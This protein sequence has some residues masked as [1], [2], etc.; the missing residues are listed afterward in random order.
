VVNSCTCGGVASSDAVWMARAGPTNSEAVVRVAIDGATGK[1]A[2]K[3]DTVYSGRFSAISVTSD[4]AAFAVDDGTFNF[5]VVAVPV[6]DAF[7]KKFPEPLI[8]ASTFVNAII[9]PDGSRVLKRRSLPDSRGS[10]VTRLSVAPFGGGDETVIELD[11]NLVGT[12]WSDSVSVKLAVQTPTGLR[13]SEYDVR[14]RTRR[15]VMDLKDS[16]V[17]AAHPVPGGWA[18]IPS[19]GSRIVISQNGV[20]REIPKPAWFYGFNNL[21]ISPDKT[22][23]L[24]G[25]WNV[26]TSDSIGYEI[27]PLAGGPARRILTR[28]AEQS[29]SMWLAD[30]SVLVGIWDTA[31][32]VALHKVGPDGRIELLGAIPRLTRSISVSQDM[33]RMTIQTR[34]YKGDAWMYRVVKQE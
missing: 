30:G 11:G 33:K 16:V 26:A 7:A 17:F 15:N 28:F 6:A 3:Q 22:Q 13:L 32:S 29:W 25:G 34:D 14:T 9:S 24:Y 8:A 2:A 21:A 1:Y 18:W 4:G 20:R 19:G 5:S 27:M 10:S 12:D 31:E 23:L